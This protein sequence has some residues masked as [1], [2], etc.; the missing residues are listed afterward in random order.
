[1]QTLALAIVLLIVGLTFLTVGAAGLI[2]KARRDQRS[3]EKA[4]EAARSR[5]LTPL[6]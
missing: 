2:W 5:E 4:E 1:M 3:R 6:P